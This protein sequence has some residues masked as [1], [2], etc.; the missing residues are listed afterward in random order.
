MPS[1]QQC[2]L[3]STILS[4]EEIDQ[5]IRKDQLHDIRNEVETESMHYLVISELPE[6][7]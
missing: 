4:D 3:R 5:Q 7:L 6:I 1:C 2:G